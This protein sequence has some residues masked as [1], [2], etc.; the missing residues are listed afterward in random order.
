MPITVLKTK[1]E[2]KD[3]VKKL[4]AR[5]DAEQKHWYV[6]DGLDLE[7]FQRW[8]PATIPTALPDGPSTPVQS[9]TPKGVRLFQLL[10]E[11]GAAVSQKFKAPVWTMAE[12]SKVDLSNGHYYLQLADRDPDGKQRAQARAVIWASNA[13]SVVPQFEAA[14]GAKLAPGIK[15][16]LHA[17]PDVSPQFGLSLVVEAI[18]PQYTLGDLEARKREIRE[19]LK[20][21]G[22]FDANKKIAP[23]WDFNA[24][25]VIAPA[26]AAGLG[27]FRVEAD[28][29][30]A[31]GLCKFIFAN[32]RFQGEG[33]PAE[34]VTAIETALA[35]WP[36]DLDAPDALVIIRG[37]GPVNDLA[38]LNDY[39][40]AKVVCTIGIPVFTGIGH[41]RDTTL[42]DEIAHRSFDTPS[43]V[44]HGIEQVIQ[45]R[46]S[47]ARRAFD[48]ITRRG[49]SLLHERKAELASVLS[50]TVSAL[51]TCLRSAHESN[52]LSISA[53]RLAAMNILARAKEQVPEQFGMVRY[54]AQR[55]IAEA[56]E[57][58]QANFVAV[59]YRA[60]RSIA[61]ARSNS[62]LASAA[63][64]DRSRAAIREANGLSARTIRNVLERA[65]RQ[66]DHAH[67]SVLAQFE[68]VLERSGAKAA[69]VR[70]GTTSI[71]SDIASAARKQISLAR[72]RSG[73]TFREINAQGPHKTLRHGFVIVR[74]EHGAPLMRAASVQVDQP[75]R[76]T[77]D[78]GDV[79]ATTKKGEGH[80]R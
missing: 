3:L 58:V 10:A 28:R 53:I 1:F 17:R 66:A 19:K 31:S 65:T 39:G 72:E 20:R 45:Q 51:Q 56:K 76:L 29:L 62:R 38:W 11:V 32:S 22:V 75:I 77:F 68:Q 8:I 59:R 78:D 69:E 67:S 73:A 40:L 26:A 70:A 35:K 44:V 7:P 52:S 63:I 50:D 27:D 43:K 55:S 79:D 13:P 54:R 15:V 36:D 48:L 61:D 24:V 4:G 16:L 2:E 74:D 14:T 18:D 33:A 30:Q 41:E 21:E 57:H 49:G 23:A 71:L 25:L 9:P 37:G 46:A 64:Q 47:E 80:D 6:P 34:I 42:L 60:Q 5:W 12:V